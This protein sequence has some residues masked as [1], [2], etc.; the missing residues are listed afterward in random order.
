MRK[1]CWCRGP[2]QTT[3]YF[4]PFPR[5][6]G[7]NWLGI[8]RDIK[9]IKA[10]LFWKGGTK[11]NCSLFWFREMSKFTQTTIR[12]KYWE[13]EKV[14]VSCPWSILPL[15]QVQCWQPANVFY[16]G[17]TVQNSNLF[18]SRLRRGSLIFWG[19]ILRG[20]LYLDFFQKKKKIG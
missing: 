15:G 5:K 2:S 6:R 16:G 9:P 8:W 18:W 4:F 19:L 17:W 20:C 1:F 14:L 7:S 13:K 12:K 10:P 11:E 3:F